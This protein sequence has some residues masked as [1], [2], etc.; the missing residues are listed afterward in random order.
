MKII[1]VIL[2]GLAPHFSLIDGEYTQDYIA[3][4][5]GVDSAKIVPIMVD[6]DWQQGDTIAMPIERWRAL[7]DTNINLKH[8]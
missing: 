7:K 1:L 8:L 5:P 6:E 3:V 2:I 4:E